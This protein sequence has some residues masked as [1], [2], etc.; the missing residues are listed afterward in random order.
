M[1]KCRIPGVPLCIGAPSPDACPLI[2][3]PNSDPDAQID[4]ADWI[5]YTN[6]KNNGITTY[7]EDGYNYPHSA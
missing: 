1:C 6:Y 3:V 7:D 2:P 4:N 5:P